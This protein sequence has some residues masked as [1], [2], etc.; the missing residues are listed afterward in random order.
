MLNVFLCYES[1][2]QL[3]AC[4]CYWSNWNTTDV[5]E[6][7]QSLMHS[8]MNIYKVNIPMHQSETKKGT[9]NSRSPVP[10][11]SHKALSKLSISY[12]ASFWLDINDIEYILFFVWLPLFIIV[13]TR[14]IHAQILLSGCTVYYGFDG[15]LSFTQ[16]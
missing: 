14:C 11:T 7:K 6:S 10:T 9:Q 12:L 3:F 4:K 1:F 5:Q 15:L 8:L 16:A 2:L 13:F